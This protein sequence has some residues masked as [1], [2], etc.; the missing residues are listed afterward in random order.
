L[1]NQL[2][3]LLTQAPDC[4]FVL[5][6]N[7]PLWNQ[8]PVRSFLSYKNCQYSPYH[9]SFWKD[10][11]LLHLTDPLPLL[12][13]VPLIPFP[14]GDLPLIATI[15][16]LIPME[17]R[18]IYL[19]KSSSV[20]REYDEK[21]AF[22]KDHCAKFLAISN[23]VAGDVQRRL[24]I[25]S[26]RVVPILGGLDPVF[27]ELPDAHVV[28]QVRRKYDLPREYFVY[29]GGTDF[30]K[31]IGTLICAFTL[32]SQRFHLPHWLVFMGEFDQRILS[33]FSK[34][35]D[36]Q[37]VLSKIKPL[38][39][40]NDEEMKGILRGATGMVFPSLYEGFGLPALEAM[41]CGTPVIA[42]NCTA[43]P[44]IIGSCGMLTEPTD[45]KGI[46]EAM[47]KLALDSQLRQE[48]SEK[49]HERARQFRWES[50][51]DK[52]MNAYQ[53]SAPARKPPRRKERRLRVLLQNRSNA[54]S[55]PGG[56][57]GIMNG[58]HEGLTALDVEVSASA[59]P[60]DL[61]GCDLVHLINLTILPAS[62]IFAQNALRQNVP[63]V[64]TTL[65][66]DWPLFLE[67][68]RHTLPLFEAYLKSGQNRELF[69]QYL[70]QLQGLPPGE[71]LENAFVA[72]GARALLA[73]GERE[74]MRLRQDFPAAAER[75]HSVPFGIHI[76][77]DLEPKYAD[78]LREQLGIGPFV[79]CVGRLETRKNQ[80]MLMKALEDDDLTLVFVAG[81]F[82][83]QPPYRELCEKFQ[84]RGHEFFVGH[85]PDLQLAALY[86]AALCH[87][88]PSWYELP[89]LVSVEAA[90][91][92]CPVVAST[93][94]S[95]A[96]YLPTD[97]FFGCQ[98]D[99]PDS[100]RNAVVQAIQSK[101]L[102][103]TAFHA[104]Q[105]TWQ[106]SAE[107]TLQIYEEILGARAPT[108][109]PRGTQESV[110]KSLDIRK[111]SSMITTNAPS[112]SLFDCS[113][114]L[115]VRD[116]AEDTERC[117][118]AISSDGSGPTY[119]VIIVD[120]GSTDRTPQLLKAIE[121]DVQ[122]LRQT[123]PLPRAQ[124]F[125]LAAKRARGKYLVFLSN[126]V[127][128]RE[129]WSKNLVGLAQ[130]DERTY[131]VGGK[132]IRPDQTVEHIGFLFRED[133]T[134]FS[135]YRG[136]SADD[137]VINQKRV[138]QAVSASCMLVR[139]DIFEKL[140]G[141]HEDLPE[142]VEDIDLCLRANA[143]GGKTVYNPEAAVSYHGNE[144]L[145]SAYTS[146]G[147]SKLLTTWSEKI[148]WDEASVLA[149]DGFRVQWTTEGAPRYQKVEEFKDE[150]L[151]EARAQRT[152]G[153]P[154][155]AWDILK[156]L[157]QH[158]PRSS[159]VMT[160]LIELSLDLHR[161]EEAESILA[162]LAP[163]QAVLL[164]RA[165]V[166]Y[167]SQK[168]GQAIQNLKEVTAHLDGLSLAE[169]FE[170]W[171]LFGTC[172][173]RLGRTE[174]AERA[175]LQALLENPSSERPYLG[176][177]S[178][179]LSAQNW[180]AA[181]YGFAIAAAHSPES[182]KAHF[183]LGLAL[184]ERGM[185]SAAT[186]EF[187]TVLQREPDHAEALFHLYKT[188]MNMG[189]PELAEIPLKSYLENHSDD[190]DFLFNLCGLQFKMGHYASAAETCRRVLALSP[191]HDAAQEVLAKLE[192][193]T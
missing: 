58:L 40:V 156:N 167:Q 7:D 47:A 136:F 154:E 6:G 116:R 16:D 125:N 121:G 76:L 165:Q 33:E 26:E 54:F 117:L 17:F 64:V 44:E 187:M 114:I 127:E 83:Y 49:S 31:N 61:S 55:H 30:R 143:L 51:A 182:A 9:P 132:L 108:R 119:E 75:V 15:Y 123:G 137:P 169:R 131:C 90:A 155:A 150:Q 28:E 193:Q 162:D 179:A 113:I 158:E 160:E 29:S 148:V 139:R 81:D 4:E 69:E 106:R 72:N 78:G 186:Q 124:S 13:K 144:S 176:L 45:Q 52:T 184:S 118:E 65:Y 39:Y 25:E 20:R 2:R 130:A 11:D 5:Y 191:E 166:Q 71:K 141:F 142:G 85:V 126:A 180:Q 151:E 147:L 185:S 23:F 10:L 21:L 111:E 59:K 91:Y 88:L 161:A 63:Y 133:K 46:A 129:G 74:A 134:P 104:R 41:A 170:A 84:R 178:A 128:P 68:S 80:L 86:I 163:N 112:S 174:D 153:H 38:G 92:G 101:P 110:S 103:D 102:A 82:T 27:L 140:G 173:T 120:N 34:R 93:W 12:P 157:V 159:Q 18:E 50:V 70:A 145:E 164:A 107:V 175:Y 67:K 192:N 60:C 122:V 48:L 97:R 183:G 189:K 3:C 43:L 89:G 95:A 100:I 105:F 146:Q 24:G 181:H 168:F 109:L 32:A 35:L 8:D 98:P 188:A 57:T 171:Q 77:D 190:T 53:E 87:V 138:F 79:L 42:S 19:R 172:Y 73:S 94:G 62:H 56:D 1:C 152:A 99:D 66:E 115:S 37:D 177:G 36:C 14:S 22:M 149:K 135:V 96:D